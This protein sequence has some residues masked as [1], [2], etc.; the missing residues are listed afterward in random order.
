MQ[1]ESKS[2]IL[3]R[4]VGGQLK[5][6]LN[7][8]MGDNVQ[9]STLRELVLQWDRSQQKWV[10][11]MVASSSTDYQ[12]PMPMDV[13][14]V[15]DAKG[16]GK[17]EHQKGK[18]KDAKGKGDQKRTEGD[19]KGKGKGRQRRGNTLHLWKGRA[20]SSRLLEIQYS[21]G[22][23]RSSTFILRRNISD[24]SHSWPTASQCQPAE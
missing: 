2:A 5:S 3:V 1:E 22:C 10:T 7:L 21:T 24:Y 9:Y 11:S 13:D 18:G 19:H 23:K 20:S 15:Q 14:R 4:C 16:K 6:Y 8:T 17:N 12:G